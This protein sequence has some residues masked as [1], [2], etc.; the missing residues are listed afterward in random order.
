MDEKGHQSHTA[1]VYITVNNKPVR[2]SAEDA[3]YFVK[4][5]DNI[6]NN[7]APGGAWNHYFTHDLDVVISR[8]VKAKEIYLKITEEAKAQGN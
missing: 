3:E 1:P 5:I 4:W 6:L 2:A 8:Y 7:I